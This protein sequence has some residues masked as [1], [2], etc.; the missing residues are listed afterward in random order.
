[1]NY[2]SM[3]SITAQDALNNQTSDNLKQAITSAI[4]NE[5]G[6]VSFTFDGLTYTASEIANN[7]TITLPLSITS[8]DNQNAQIPGVTLSYNNIPLTWNTSSSSSSTASSSSSSNTDFIVEGFSSSSTNKTPSP[9]P[10]PGPNPSNNQPIADYYS[11]IAKELDAELSNIIN[12]SSDD[13]E[14]GQSSSNTS[15]NNNLIIAVKAALQLELQDLNATFSFNGGTYTIKQVVSNIDVILPSSS[16]NIDTDIKQ[17]TIPG[18]QLKL[19]SILL[20]N[21]AK[22]NKFT[23]Q[24]IKGDTGKKI[25]NNITQSQIYSEIANQLN[26]ILSNIITVSNYNTVYANSALSSESAENLLTSA[27]QSA[28]TT[29]IQNSGITFSFTTEDDNITYSA[30]EIVQDII[31]TFPASTSITENDINDGQIPGVVLEFEGILLNNTEKTNTFIIEGFKTNTTPIKKISVTAKA[32]KYISNQLDNLLSNDITVS[33]YKQTTASDALSTTAS[34]NALIQAIK[35]ALLQEIQGSGINFDY[36][37]PTYTLSYTPQQIINN[38]NVT[39]P[40]GSLSSSNN[41]EGQIPGVTLTYEDITLSNTSG[42]WN[43][44]IVGFLVS[45]AVQQ[46]MLQDQEIAQYIGQLLASNGGTG[47]NVSNISALSNTLANTWLESAASEETLTTYIKPLLIQDLIQSNND[48]DNFVINNENYTAADLVNNITFTYPDSIPAAMYDSL[49]TMCGI[50]LKYNGFIIDD[51]SDSFNFPTN[52]GGDLST[53][54]LINGFEL[55]Q[56]DQYWS[57]QNT[58][59]ITK[60]NSILNNV[61]EV[62]G[63]SSTTA[64][65]SISTTPNQNNLMFAIQEAIYNEISKS[66]T[67]IVINHTSYTLDDIVYGGGPEYYN[68]NLPLNPVAEDNYV[69]N[70]TMSGIIITLPKEITLNNTQDGLIPDVS[71][72][73]NGLPLTNIQGESTFTITGFA[74]ITS[75]K[76]NKTVATWLD[77]ILPQ[78][79]K[80]TGFSD[81]TASDALTSPY[82]SKLKTAIK[83]VI[84]QEIINSKYKLLF[85]NVSFS[86]DEIIQGLSI[87]LPV[88]VTL[89]DEE[90]GMMSNVT[91]QYENIPLSNDNSTNTS[92]TS[93]IVEGF[94]EV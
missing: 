6:S 34:Q 40:T 11:Q 56:S 21:T 14:T 26:D 93:F 47:V 67:T 54:F 35:T 36:Q 45:Q 8:I 52:D 37:T 76:V 33:G 63:Y 68:T 73:Y 65:S 79:I 91:I 58:Q 39:L 3:N 10:T 89:N 77:T 38:I 7:I 83:N 87:T 74:K 48:H 69:A 13:F 31:I 24:F 15:I 23:I 61:I 12:I 60:L 78:I 1:A 86:A 64:S 71:I 82:P 5:I 88:G 55:A 4:Q 70:L 32:A 66:F 80:V 22:T 29:E 57:N 27:V 72:Q 2:D 46:K 92:P 17:G 81:I 42:S 94:K 85:D 62:N 18:V 75:D 51:P 84:E 53:T 59:M 50:G 28:L 43:F 16:S 49:G 44:T 20:T 25:K 19:G 41:S 90:K 9:N 30:K